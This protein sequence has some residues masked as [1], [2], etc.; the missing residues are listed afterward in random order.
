MVLLSRFQVVAGY[1]QAALLSGRCLGG[2]L[3]QILMATSLCDYYTVNFITLTSMIL[4]TLPKY[5]PVMLQFRFILNF[6]ITNYHKA[7]KFTTL[8]KNMKTL[9]YNP[10]SRFL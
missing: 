10:L 6:F 7:N 9:N 2:V 1:T 4:A 3:R 5:I 8:R